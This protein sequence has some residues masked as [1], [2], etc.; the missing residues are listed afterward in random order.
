[1][2]LTA[3]GFMQCNLPFVHG[4]R[5]R[6]GKWRYYFRRKGK[7]T[8]LPGQPGSVEFLKCYSA[9]IEPQ[10]VTLE[11]IDPKS[12]EALCRA[13]RA[14]AAFSELSKSYKTNMGYVIDQLIRDH[15]PKPARLLRRKHV[16]E[17][18]NA[19]KHK[20]GACNN[21]LRT[22]RIICAYGV[23]IEAMDTNPASKIKLMKGGEHRAWT[24]KELAIFEEKWA[25]GT[26]ERFIFDSALYSGQRAG[27]VDALSRDKMEFG[28]I[29]LTQ[30]KTGKDMALRIHARW[31]LSMD[32]YLATHTAPTLI[33]GRR[34]KAIHKVTMS[35][36]FRDAKRAAGL[37][38][39]C[40]LHGLRKTT[41]RILAELKEKS[42]PVTGH[43]T[44]A[45]QEK[46]E[47]DAD[48]E[49]LATA[50][51]ISWEQKKKVANHKD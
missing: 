13:Y 39:D 24:D 1:M 20:P 9:C 26:L 17:M 11:G 30:H 19:L 36:I 27:D 41:A 21:M 33:A 4:Y 23:D 7:R 37:P 47:R 43:A 29:K 49:G 45:M 48:Q 42:T 18:K 50:A 3:G 32:A 25:V 5:D 8:A 22:I 16:I 51:I 44:R 14:S 2:G 6:H 10:P 35:A 31:Q 28:K 15:G 38:E 46:Y 40:V 12:F 34:G